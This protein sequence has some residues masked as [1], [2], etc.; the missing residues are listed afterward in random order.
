MKMFERFGEF[1]SV[2]ELNAAAEGLLKEGD[3]ESIYVLAAENGIE[4]ED[5]EEY[6]EG[7]I[8]Q[9]TSLYM[10][11]IGR[12][13]VQEASYKNEDSMTGMAL[14]VISMTLRGMVQKETMAAAVMKKGKR[15]KDIYEVMREDASKNKSGNMAMVCGTDE[16][17]RNIIQAYFMQG[18]EA[19]GKVIA[20]LRK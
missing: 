3:C 12:I 15:I 16:D 8:P 6:V 13:D 19:A 17:L 9:F 11:A 5:V 10:A 7:Y 2:E 1:D 14:K 20:D 4:Q 18:K